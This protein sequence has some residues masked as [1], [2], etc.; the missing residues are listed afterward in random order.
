MITILKNAAVL[1]PEPLGQKDVAI[2]AGRILAVSQRIDAPTGIEAEVLDCTDLILLPGLVDGHVHIAGAGGEG[3]PS[4]RTPEMMLG[5]FL[6][7]GVTTVIGMLGVDGFTRP[8]ESVLMKARALTEEGMSAFILTGSYQLP[9]RTI[10]GDVARDI[11]LIPEVVGVGEVAV[12]DHRD[13]APT[14]HE[15]ARLAKS[16]RVAA[17]LAGKTGVVCLHLGDAPRSFERIT[18]AVEE[19]GIP[20]RHFL[21]THCNRSR[22]VFDRTAEFAAQGGYVDITTSA[23]PLFPDEEVKPSA[24]VVWLLEKGI[25]AERISVSSDAGGSLPDFDAQGNLRD[26]ATGRPESLFSEVVDLVTRDR[27]PLEQ[28]IRF[29]S[30]YPAARYGLAGKGRI[31]PGADA[32]LIAV[33]GGFTIRHVIARGSFAVRDGVQVK[34]GR[35]EKQER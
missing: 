6:M 24:A 28:A 7:A 9:L 30:Q 31:V 23:Y 10:S 15:I 17:M 8:A 1:S 3:G 14:W 13:S 34:F 21:P 18:Q 20:W 11:L 27:V 35:F 26:L 4:T 2:A 22:D 29:A 19:E 5:D 16:V 25:P 32:D 12:A 33:D